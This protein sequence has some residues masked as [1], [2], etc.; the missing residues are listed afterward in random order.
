MNKPDLVAWLEYFDS[1]AAASDLIPW[2]D[3]HDVLSASEKA[4][5]ES[6]IAK[7]QLGEYS[8]AHSLLGFAVAFADELGGYCLVPITRRFVKEEQKHALMLKR[9]MQGHAL[10]TLQRNWTDTLFRRLRKVAGYEASITVLITAELIALVYYRALQACTQ[11][12]VLVAICK[13]ILEEE[14]AH[15]RY[16]SELLRYIRERRTGF[17]RHVPKVLHRLLY[18]GTVVVVFADHRRVLRRGGYGF[19]GFWSACWDKF[20]AAF[21]KVD[22]TL[23]RAWG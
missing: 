13:R 23:R 2:G 18:A 15:T 14:A 10:R 9:F 17:L 8:E 21:A 6:S 12:P 7:F 5:I 3:P 4:C 19:V 1:N 11:S 20:S 16:E 22:P